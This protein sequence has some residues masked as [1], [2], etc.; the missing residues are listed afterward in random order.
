MSSH[1]WRGCLKRHP[2]LPA[3]F[4]SH[5]RPPNDPPPTPQVPSEQYRAEPWRPDPVL[6]HTGRDRATANAIAH[7]L[8]PKPSTTA[9]SLRA[10]REYLDAW[11]Q[12]GG[13]ESGSVPGEVLS[14]LGLTLGSSAKILAGLYV[15]TGLVREQV[16]PRGHRGRRGS[17]PHA[18]AGAAEGWMAAAALASTPHPTA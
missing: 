18:G 4:A 6:L 9:R 8:L 11:S 10:V 7:N 14:M 13:A 5:R 3:A 2:T 12:S 1:R 16:G 17:G 15:E